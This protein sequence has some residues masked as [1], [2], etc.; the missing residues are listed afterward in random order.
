VPGEQHTFGLLMVAE[1]FRR[2]GWEVWSGTGGEDTEITT[3]V[4]AERFAIAGFS[5]AHEERL[6]TLAGVIRQVR[7]A[8][9]NR[10]IG[11][12][13]GGPLFIA[14][15]EL[16]LQV[17]ADATASDGQQA[18]LQAETLLALDAARM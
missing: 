3:R 4:K 1:F 14:H 13:V 10:G 17:G 12:L 11:I 18:V 9:L 15:P 8:S 7:R 2:G 6:V 5:L 16:V